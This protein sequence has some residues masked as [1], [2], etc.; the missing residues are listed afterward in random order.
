MRR[1]Y[2]G[3]ALRGSRLAVVSGAAL[4]AGLAALVAWGAALGF[5]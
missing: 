4:V 3:A 2:L 5:D 1:A